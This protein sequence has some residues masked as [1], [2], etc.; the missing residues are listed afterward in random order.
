L[1]ELAKAKHMDSL[2]EK[3]ILVIKPLIPPDAED[4]VFRTVRQLNKPIRDHIRAETGLRLSDHQAR[5]SI[6]VKVT[7]GFPAKLAGL[8]GKYDDPVLWRL[9]AAQPRLGGIVEG[10]QFLLN[11][12]DAFEKWPA[13]PAVARGSQ[14][15]M[16]RSR[17]VAL[18][19]QQVT[20]SEQVKKELTAIHEDILGAY[21]FATGKST[22]GFA[23]W[24]EI[25]W[26]P[27]A[28]IAAMLDVHIEDITVVTLAHE[29]A[30]GYTH[31][32][33]DIDGRCWNDKGFAESELGVVEG[34]AQFYTKIVTEKLFARSPGAHHAYERLLELQS[35]PYL[36]HDVWLKDAPGQRGETVRFAMLAARSHGAVKCKEW[37]TMLSDTSATL[38]RKGGKAT[39]EHN[40]FSDPIG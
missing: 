19:L 9:I 33:R 36:V 7:E 15:E 16:E 14:P 8:I 40:L 30:H 35:G 29:L 39:P 12:W 27:I 11:E 37:E 32:G 5:S 28:L 3:A 38:K 21:W 22:A 6:P 17:D 10:L 13:L 2:Q 18:A 26:M 23:P 34:L 4:R 20:L 1:T 25:Y 31:L 24:V